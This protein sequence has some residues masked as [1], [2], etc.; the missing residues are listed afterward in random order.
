[1]LEFLKEFSKENHDAI[2]FLPGDK[3]GSIKIEGATYKNPGEV[4]G[5]S[6]IGDAYHIILFKEDEETEEL[7]NVDSF[8]GIFIDPL[9]YMSSLITQDWYG[10]VARKTTTSTDFI[11]KTF[12]KLLN[13]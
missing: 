4:I 9:E 1:M 2:F 7:Y 5:G 8:E 3:K 12:D 13:V 6:N 11:Q 10:I